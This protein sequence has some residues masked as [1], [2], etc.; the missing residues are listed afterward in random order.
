MIAIL[1]RA[2]LIASTP[3]PA[4]DSTGGGQS[5]CRGPPWPHRAGAPA[6]RTRARVAQGWPHTRSVCPVPAARTLADP[7][8]PAARSAAAHRP[9]A[10]DHAA[11]RPT[12][13]RI[14]PGRLHRGPRT[15]RPAFAAG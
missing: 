5:T 9:A 13:A 8:Q 10:A 15:A 2:L 14:R 1:R 4:P 11:V 3:A 7:G 6:D 12:T